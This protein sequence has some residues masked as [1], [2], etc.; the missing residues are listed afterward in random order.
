MPSSKYDDDEGIVLER[1]LFDMAFG[2][3]QPPYFAII[4]LSEEERGAEAD[5]QF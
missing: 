5:R 3:S 4:G 1:L 2:T